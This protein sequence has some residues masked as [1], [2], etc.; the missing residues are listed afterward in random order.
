MM[1]IQPIGIIRSPYKEK[2]GVPRQ[3]NLVSLGTGELH[4]LPPFNQAECV[5]GL[6]QFSHL[7]LLFVFN[8][9][10]AQG[11][12]PTV[13]PPRLGG[14]EKMGVFASR[15]TFRPNPI[16]LSAVELQDI[17]ID[18]DRIILQLGSVDIVDNTPI[19]DIKPY[20]PYSDCYPDAKAGYA[21]NK[22]GKQLTVQFN[23]HT[24]TQLLSQP[25]LQQLIIQVI[26]QDPRPAY[27]QKSLKRQEFGISLYQ[28]NIRFCVENNV[29]T[30][31]SIE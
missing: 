4:L 26:S 7:W 29:A 18:K 21:N 17:C 1:N 13:R 25:A 19:I 27:K 5:R 31:V 15:S 24:Q 3:P 6:E 9:T 23:Q 12:Q 22:P 2:F 20:I 11:W 8:Q 28:F 16:G 10:M 14:N 30:I